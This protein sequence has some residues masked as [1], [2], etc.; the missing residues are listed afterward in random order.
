MCI[1]DRYLDQL[2][3]S[4]GKAL[5]GFAKLA[6]GTGF[7]SPSVDI[8]MRNW[9][10]DDKY[11]ETDWNPDTLF[12]ETGVSDTLVSACLLYTSRCV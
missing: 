1:R 11:Q 2:E 6:D 9:K 4:K 12:S 7:S 10:Y 3:E 5:Q 8:I